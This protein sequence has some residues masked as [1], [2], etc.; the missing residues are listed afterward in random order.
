MIIS[1]DLVGVI[2]SV[3]VFV[4]AFYFLV[5]RLG[6]VS[7]GRGPK[8]DAFSGGEELPPERGKYHS[9]LFVYAAL[10]V[11]FEVVG[12]LIAS[13]IAARGLIWQLLFT[14][15]GGFS[16]FVLMIW[17]VGTGGAELA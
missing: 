12:L 15:A 13:S 14:L 9:E 16:L 6:R 2:L 4:L 3:I 1:F 17:F 8:F 5:G 11:A 7:T 10:F